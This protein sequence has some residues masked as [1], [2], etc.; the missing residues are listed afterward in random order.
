MR[1]K[2]GKQFPAFQIDQLLRPH[3]EVPEN[4]FAQRLWRIRVKPAR[5]NALPRCIRKLHIPSG[6]LACTTDPA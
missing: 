6:R 5:N 1:H 2:K 4:L 3:P